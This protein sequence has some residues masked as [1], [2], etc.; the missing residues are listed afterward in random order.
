MQL[1]ELA[2]D[3][4]WLTLIVLLLPL[5]IPFGVLAGGTGGGCAGEALRD[6]G[7]SGRTFRPRPAWDSGPTPIGAHLTA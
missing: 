3:L 7:M 2:E 1:R 5:A 4:G 6:D